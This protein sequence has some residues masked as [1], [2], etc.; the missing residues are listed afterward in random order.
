MTRRGG[1]AQER[2]SG[3]WVRW[4]T[5]RMCCKSQLQLQHCAAS[6]LPFVA[7]TLAN[8]PSQILSSHPPLCVEESRLRSYPTQTTAL[9]P[10]DNL[11]SSIP[12]LLLHAS[13]ARGGG[14]AGVDLLREAEGAH[15][16][17]Q[18]GGAGREVAEHEG[19]RV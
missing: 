1:V 18:V 9:L 7:H 15:A 19:L 17:V 4:P 13:V 12:L 8:C 6:V 3:V 2:Q 14:G 5:A 10:T 11:S 16:L